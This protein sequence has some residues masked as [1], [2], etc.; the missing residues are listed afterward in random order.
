MRTETRYMAGAKDSP[1]AD[2][3]ARALMETGGWSVEAMRAPGFR[4]LEQAV[5]D[6]RA[7]RAAAPLM[8]KAQVAIDKAVVE[9]GL[10]RLTF[11]ADLMAEGLVYNLPDP[12]SV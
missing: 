7:F 9:V 6:D 8:D 11:V 4:L 1:L 5:A 10:Q 2:L 3:V 12:L